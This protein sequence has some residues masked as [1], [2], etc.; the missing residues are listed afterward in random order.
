MPTLERKDLNNLKELE[1]MVITPEEARKRQDNGTQKPAIVDGERADL[2]RLAEK[3]NLRGEKVD[4]GKEAESIGLS[5]ED[6]QKK[7][8][9]LSGGRDD[10][11][12]AKLDFKKTNET[13][14]T[15][16]IDGVIWD[17]LATD[18]VKGLQGE[19]KTAK[20]LVVKINSPGGSV[21]AGIRIYDELMEFKGEVTTI[22]TGEAASMGSIIAMAG[23]VRKM[24]S[25]SQMMAHEVSPTENQLE[26]FLDTVRKANAALKNIYVTRAGMSKDAVDQMFAG[27]DTYFS[28]VEAQEAGLVTEVIESGDA[29]PTNQSKAIWAFGDAQVELQTIVNLRTEKATPQQTEPTGELDMT[30]TAWL[31][32]KDI[33]HD[34][35]TESQRL[36]WKQIYDSDPANEDDDGDLEGVLADQR[37]SY[38]KQ[39]RR[40]NDITKKCEGFPEIAAKAVEENWDD[41]KIEDKLT[42]ARLEKKTEPQG[43][44]TDDDF[45]GGFVTFN[46]VERNSEQAKTSVNAMVAAALLDMGV[47]EDDILD[48]LRNVDRRA[49]SG[50][51]KTSPWLSG[52]HKQGMKEKDID[53][54][55]TYF[56]GGFDLRQMQ[57]Y[58]SRM[59]GLD[60]GLSF[61]HTLTPTNAVS[62]FQ[63]PASLMQITERRMLASEVFK[64]MTYRDFV[65]VRSVNDMKPVNFYDTSN[66]GRW[67]KAT[68]DGTLKAGSIRAA[69]AFEIQTDIEGLYFIVAEQHLING[70]FGPIAAMATSFAE[71]GAMTPEFQSYD[72]LNTAQFIGG[73]IPWPFGGSAVATNPASGSGNPYTEIDLLEKMWE[74]FVRKSSQR[75]LEN[76]R[77]EAAGKTDRVRRLNP[78]LI[79]D[80]ADAPRWGKLLDGGVYVSGGTTQQTTH[81]ENSFRN[82]FRAVTEAAYLDILHGAIM[83]PQPT[84]ASSAISLAALGGRTVPT[85]TQKRD[86]KIDQ[87]GV[88]I[89]G[90]I[91]TEAVPTRTN[92][93]LTVDEAL[94]D[95]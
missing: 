77:N 41:E 71:T 49:K 79:H 9:S 47:N 24:T 76:D 52:S 18:I 5:V 43:S 19:F 3:H 56:G 86:L 4:I 62:T 72:V 82:R 8:E 30:F 23:D 1:D 27:K 95:L 16:N 46:I 31:K 32:A 94:A 12:L 63:F 64:E 53:N 44:Q 80:F 89:Q 50:I 22:V 14:A 67:Q 25:G 85:I 78:V 11:C 48:P 70:D 84:D 39:L 90:K 35:L 10:I 93:N 38:A 57:F 68:R 7:L 88:G 13:A 15:L 58:I 36:N 59:N 20:N 83:L 91:Y 45:G 61:D 17:G 40:M 54:A 51:L 55:L 73:T 34:K 42:I 2:I 87:L 69:D 29:E 28:A 74:L 81:S 65:R 75:Q 33:E 66:M 92:R 60:K 37:Q 6:Y 21:S 26:G